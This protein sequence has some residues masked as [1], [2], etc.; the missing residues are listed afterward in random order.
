LPTAGVCHVKATAF[1]ETVPCKFCGALG[2]ILGV[3]TVGAVV[4]TVGVVGGVVGTVGVG[5]V[6]VGTVGVGTVGVGIGV[7]TVGVGV[8]DEITGAGGAV[9]GPIKFVPLNVYHNAVVASCP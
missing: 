9:T 1:P 3:G 5:T 6:G 2:A 7:G 4:G 8:G